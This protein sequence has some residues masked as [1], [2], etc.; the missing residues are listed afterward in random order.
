L[1][2]LNDAAAYQRQRG[3]A[4]TLYVGRSFLTLT[5]RILARRRDALREHLNPG[6]PLFA[7]QLLPGLGAADDPGTG[8]SFGQSR[9]RLVSR[10]L[11]DAWRCERIDPAARFEAVQDCFHRA[12]LALSFPHLNPGQADPYEWP[13]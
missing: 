5:L 2:C 10:G 13:D 11:I 9:M 6:I 4:V 1:K 12:G 7:R 3:D 8:E